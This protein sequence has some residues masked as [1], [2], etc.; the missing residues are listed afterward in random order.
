MEKEMKV[1]TKG[2]VC[3]RRLVVWIAVIKRLK[4]NILRWFGHMESMLGCEY[5]STNKIDGT[6]V[7]ERKPVK[8]GK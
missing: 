1:S 2:L 5:I 6:D 3:L 7:N 8:W 4:W